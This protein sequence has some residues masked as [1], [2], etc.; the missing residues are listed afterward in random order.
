MTH[1]TI[2]AQVPTPAEQPAPAGKPEQPKSHA[3][4][5]KAVVELTDA[6]LQAVSGGGGRGGLGGDF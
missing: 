2:Q 6:E 4:K 3:G 1:E 5:K